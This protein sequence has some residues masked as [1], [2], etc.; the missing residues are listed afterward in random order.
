VSEPGRL[1]QSKAIRSR[2]GHERRKRAPNGFATAS[3]PAALERHRPGW[4]CSTDVRRRRPRES[5]ARGEAARAQACFSTDMAKSPTYVARLRCRTWHVWPEK[6][7]VGSSWFKVDLGDGVPVLAQAAVLSYLNRTQPNDY[8]PE[9][10]ELGQLVWRGEIPGIYFVREH[11]LK[12]PEDVNRIAFEHRNA[13]RG[14]IDI[15]LALAY[16]GDLPLDAHEAVRRVLFAI[17]SLINLRHNDYLTPSAPMQIAKQSGDGKQEIDSS[18]R[19]TVRER[20]TLTKP[21]LAQSL[22]DFAEAVCPSSASAKLQVALELYGAHFVETSVRARFLLLVM[23]LEV[24]ATATQRSAAALAL[25]EK[26]ST[27]A[28]AAAAELEEDAPERGDLDDLVKGV[29]FMRQGSIRGRVREL[30]RRSAPQAAEGRAWAKRGVALYDLRSRLVHDGFLSAA[31]L[32]KGSLEAVAIVEMVLRSEIA[33]AS[34]AAE[35]GPAVATEP[36]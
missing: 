12:A 8:T 23:V 31:D 6:T 14:E 34:A 20:V 2:V 13:N 18:F 16:P 28:K 29:P 30:V 11:A 4:R 27:E 19:V 24:L 22:N 35:S 1:F 9:P 26:W 7:A 17:L 10:T 36:P 33:A 15:A 32:E 5:P 3:L 25:L 21:D